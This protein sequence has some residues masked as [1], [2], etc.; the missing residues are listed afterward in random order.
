MR[1]WLG[2]LWRALDSGGDRLPVGDLRDLIVDVLGLVGVATAVMVVVGL[3]TV[4]TASPL[5]TVIAVVL[6]L[7]PLGLRWLV[8]RTPTAVTVP[9][10][11]L[12]ASAMALL[13]V[14]AVGSLQAVQSSLLLLPLM[15][16]TFIYGPALGL[17]GAGL[18]ALTAF[19]LAW[20]LPH[21]QRV[22]NIAPVNQAWILTEFAFITVLCVIGLRRYVARA[23]RQAVEARAR[24][25]E[26]T[27]RGE[28][29]CPSAC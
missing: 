16:A 13:W 23:H 27:I 11:L 25:V 26:V 3:A 20:I 22:G 7:A 2:N 28:P 10:L 8:Q 12:G 9:A 17:L 4:P 1:T 21:P 15:F 19:W 24:R 5:A 18:V 29:T 14:L 6:G